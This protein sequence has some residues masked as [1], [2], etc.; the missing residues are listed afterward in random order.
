[1]GQA[2]RRW[3]PPAHGPTGRFVVAG[4]AGRFV[5]VRPGATYSSA[6]LVAVVVERVLTAR[7]RDIGVARRW[8]VR[9]SAGRFP[10]AGSLLAVPAMTS[11]VMA[12]PMAPGEHGANPA[13]AS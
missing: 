8:D 13:T 11:V 3:M 1:M 7:T 9:R 2:G 10:G 12:E 6:P 5:P 4:L